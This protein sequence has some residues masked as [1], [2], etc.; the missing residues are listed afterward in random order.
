MNDDEVPIPVLWPWVIAA[1]AVLTSGLLGR[2]LLW[3]GEDTGNGFLNAGPGVGRIILVIL[4]GSVLT[5][6]ALSQT[7]SGRWRQGL[8]CISIEALVLGTVAAKTWFGN[9]CVSPGDKCLVSKGSGY[10]MLLLCLAPL[11]LGALYSRTVAGD[12]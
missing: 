6:L 5:P 1:G 7:A 9:A 11:V 12:A 8:V 4:T 2:A 10:L 3:T